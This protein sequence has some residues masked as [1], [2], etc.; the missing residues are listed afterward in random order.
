MEM[1]KKALRVKYFLFVIKITLKTYI[2]AFLHTYVSRYSP[3]RSYT[4]FFCE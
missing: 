4:I 3:N 2:D 1:I